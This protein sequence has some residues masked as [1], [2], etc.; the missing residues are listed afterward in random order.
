MPQGIRLEDVRLLMG[1][2][3]EDDVPL[4]N[5]VHKHA[6]LLKQLLATGHADRG[7]RAH[8]R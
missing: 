5:A 6:R 4:A 2:A 7:H 3:V 1:R 8:P